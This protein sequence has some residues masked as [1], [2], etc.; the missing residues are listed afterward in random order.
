VDLKE[1]ELRKVEYVEMFKGCHWI[2]FGFLKV[3]ARH[4]RWH[5]IH[6]FEDWLEDLQSKEG[7]GRFRWVRVF[8]RGVGGEPH[9]LH[10]LIGGLRSRRRTW[11]KRWSKRGRDSFLRHFNEHPKD[12]IYSIVNCMDKDGNLDISY[13]LW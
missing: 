8:E 4:S 5:A 13:R 10:I 7:G 11:Q 12:T 6:K 2:W 1:L 9:R 3:P